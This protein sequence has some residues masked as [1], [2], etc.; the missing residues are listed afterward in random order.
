[1][2]IGCSGVGSR[3]IRKALVLDPDFQENM[4]IIGPLNVILGGPRLYLVLFNV[5]LYFIK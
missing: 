3:A 4:Y 1:M 5:K 2:L